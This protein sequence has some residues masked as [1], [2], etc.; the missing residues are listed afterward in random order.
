M[1]HFV[2]GVSDDL[3]EE[4]CLVM[5]HDNMDISRLMLHAQQVEETRLK[6]NNREFKW[7]K[8]YE[9]GTS[10]VRLEI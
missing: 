4:C 1:R 9:R 5:P 2:T 8:S 3:A 7:D 10:K 6:R